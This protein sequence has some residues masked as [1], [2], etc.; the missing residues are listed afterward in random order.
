MKHECKVVL[1]ELFSKLL[2]IT[3]V[4]NSGQLCG[5]IRW[6]GFQ[7][8]DLIRQWNNNRQKEDLV[9]SVCK[10]TFANKMGKNE[11]MKINKLR[12][13]FYTVCNHDAVSGCQVTVIVNRRARRTLQISKEHVP[14]VITLLKNCGSSWSRIVFSRCYTKTFHASEILDRVWVKYWNKRIDSLTLIKYLSTYDIK[15]NKVKKTR[16]IVQNW[17]KQIFF[18]LEFVFED[19]WKMCYFLSVTFSKNNTECFSI[20]YYWTRINLSKLDLR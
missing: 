20:L 15:N 1:R 8:S 17:I 19:E 16:F 11:L 5:P 2:L 4:G 9:L 3:G 6:P 18:L 12:R 14:A 10:E 13:T 7:D